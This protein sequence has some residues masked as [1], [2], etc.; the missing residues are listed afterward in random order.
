MNIGIVVEGADDYSTYPTIIGRIRNDIERRQVRQCGGKSRLKGGFLRFLKEFQNPAWQ[1]DLA[2]VIRDS[3]CSP[4]KPLEDELRD[5]LRASN[6][7][8]PFRV[9]LFAIPCMLES[10][11]ISDVQAIQNVAIQRGHGGPVGALDMQ[12]PNAH[13]RADKQLFSRVLTHFELPATPPVYEQVAKIANFEIIKQRCRYFQEFVE[14]LKKQ[15]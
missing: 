14:R 10:W 3:D 11:L 6:L 5:V 4:P 9:E 2:V 13:S 12:I 7:R 8:T 1:I 15:G